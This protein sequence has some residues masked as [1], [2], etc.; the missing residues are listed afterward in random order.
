MLF[1]IDMNDCMPNDKEFVSRTY[2]ELLQIN[3]KI[4]FKWTKTLNFLKE[5]IQK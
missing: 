5:Y 2:N 4:I 1:Y 3:N